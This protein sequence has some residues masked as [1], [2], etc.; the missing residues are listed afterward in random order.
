MLSTPAS[1]CVEKG[2]SRV[3]AP[4]EGGDGQRRPE[5]EQADGQQA[6]G[7]QPVEVEPGEGEQVQATGEAGDGGAG[8][9]D[10]EQQ[11][12]G[13]EWMA[14]HGRLLCQR[15]DARSMMIWPAPSCRSRS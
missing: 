4:P 11:G 15:S 9:D 2:K 10:A 13:V 5:G 3:V 12:Q 8:E 7:Q 1:G 14:G 6:D